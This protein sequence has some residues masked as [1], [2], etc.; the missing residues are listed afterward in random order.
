MY[1]SYVTRSGSWT[2]WSHAPIGWEDCHLSEEADIAEVDWFAE[3]VPA[4]GIDKGS[5][6]SLNCPVF[7]REFQDDPTGNLWPLDRLA[8]CKLAALPHCSH[9]KNLVVVSRFASFMQQIPE[10]ASE[11]SSSSF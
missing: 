7:Q 8:P 5:S 6:T 4:A 9:A 11:A 3:T 10:V 1:K 2:N